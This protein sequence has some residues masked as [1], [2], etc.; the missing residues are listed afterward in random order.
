MSTVSH[1]TPG[2]LSR[3]SDTDTL[4]NV[5]GLSGEQARAAL[6]AFESVVAADPGASPRSAEL[7]RV[8][9]ATLEVPFA[10]GRTEPVHAE[11]LAVLFPLPAQRR[12]L[13][14]ALIVAVCIEGEVHAGRRVVMEGLAAA[15]GVRSPF[16]G[17][18]RALAAGDVLA[19]KRGLVLRSPDARALFRRTW[20]EEGMLGVLRALCFVLGL[21]RNAALAS[22]FRSLSALPAGSFGRAVSEHFAAR[23]LAFPGEAGGMPERMIH[24]DLMHVLNGYDT[25]PAGECEI[26]GFYCGFSE[27]EPFTFIMTALATFQLGLPVSP[28]VV[29][30]TRGAF[31]PARVLAAFMR[32]KRLAVDVTGAWDY[33]SLMALPLP[34]ARARLGLGASTGGPRRAPFAPFFLLMLGV[35]WLV[36]C[37]GEGGASAA[38]ECVPERAE[39]ESRVKPLIERYC[40]TCHG[41]VPSFGAPVALTGYD[42]LTAPRA[43]GRLSARV[44]E[45]TRDGTMP[46][47]GMPRL[48][49]EDAEAITRWASCG[50]LGAP[51][52]GGLVSSAAPLIAPDEAPVG[53]AQLDLLAPEH[54]V[55]VDTQDEYWCFVF[56]ADLPGD[57][58]V[59]RFEMV[60]G[61]PRVLHHLIVARDVDKQLAPGNY[62][63]GGGEGMPAGSQYLYAWAPGQQALQFPSGGLRVKPGDRLVVT[64]HYNNG[65]RIP[66][67]RDSSGVR[68]YLAPP[69]GTEYGMFAVGS[70]G[71]T[72]APRRRT[73]VASRCE[74]GTPTTLFGGMPHMHQLG[75]AFSTHLERAGERT[76]LVSLTGWDFES[77]LFY[78]F[79]ASLAPGDV[80]VTTCTYDNPRDEAVR[81]GEG[82]G[83]EMCN[84]FMYATPPPKAAF[85]DQGNAGAGGELSYA[86][87]ACLTPPVDAAPPTVTGGWVEARAPRALAG[88][89]VQDGTWI[90]DAVEFG[91]TG[92]DTPLG[93]LD[94]ANSRV[95]AR[96]QLQLAGGKLTVDV[97]SRALV[98]LGSGTAIEQDTSVSFRLPFDPA[99]ESLTGQPECP[100]DAPAVEAQW[101]MNGD[102]LE[103]TFTRTGVPGMSVFPWY[104]F[105]RR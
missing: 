13:V 23:G 41:D 86:A 21:Y 47:T 67:V 10:G 73:E 48:P 95:T 53:L 6:S 39:Y 79:P 66:D 61:E 63:C 37:G 9:A 27:G 45:R 3:P 52:A 102:S 46:P 40:G 4:R 83:D 94:F 28:A 82:T 68:L 50:A 77:Q 62:A 71:F 103:L 34:E 32:G 70:L 93:A 55:S 65:A 91:S 12:T 11:Q 87:S 57:R 78:S 90:L 72:L 20:R 101:G 64:I 44:A 60:Y 19:F 88:G 1:V 36:G 29:K 99:A 49:A 16:V 69:E 31:D 85:C 54:P 25:D 104:R 8:A 105:R 76:P 84:N 98:A 80:L 97:V 51:D 42:A 81:F 26:A 43:E 74:I 38:P 14:D 89:S 75:S 59:R 5:F 17:M 96:G 92:G 58:F 15:L 33:W 24:H 18:L 2:P 7:L 35:L 100:A 22:R 56:D 30:P